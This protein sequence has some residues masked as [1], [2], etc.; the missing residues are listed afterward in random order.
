MSKS[1]ETAKISRSFYYYQPAPD[2]DIEV[3]AAIQA[4]VKKHPRWGFWLI[5]D[6]LRLEGHPWNHKRLWRIYCQLGLNLRRHPKKRLPKRKKQPITPPEAP[7][8]CWALDFTSDNLLTG[9]NFRTLNIIDEF[10]RE[11]LGIEVDLSL[12]AQR[13]IR[14][15]DQII[16]WRGTPQSLRMDN[17]P[18]FIAQALSE[19]ADKQNVELKFIQPG[20]PT[21]NPYIERFNG[22]F[23]FEVLNAHL[24]ENLED[25][26][27]ISFQW[28]HDYNHERPHRSLNGIPPALKMKQLTSP[29][30]TRPLKIRENLANS[31]PVLR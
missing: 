21:Q 11:A 2:P 14:V 22:T 1:C 19:W 29:L 4:L 17:G 15:L 7:N 25:A 8:V 24:F 23:R 27:D 16:E 30:K 6:K 18:E 13:V 12:P 28:M 10:N 9:K 3:I 31:R 20:K 5:H 26:Q